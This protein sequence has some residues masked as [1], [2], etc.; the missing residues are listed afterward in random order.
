MS[1][2]SPKKG[3]NSEVALIR[4]ANRAAAI[5]RLMLGEIRNWE[6]FL[7]ADT[8]KL[9]TLP[10]R[11]L[12]HAAG[13]V[14]RSV[15]K[16]V[17]KFCNQ[18]FESMTEAKLES[19]YEE[20]KTFRGLELPLKEFEQRFAKV[21]KKVLKSAP[22]H[23]TV[24]ISLWGLKFKFPEDYLAKDL[25]QALSEAL[26]ANSELD[27]YQNAPHRTALS[28][29]D[30]ITPILRKGDHACR[31]CL[32]IC[33]NLLESYL[34]GIAWDFS[35][36]KSAFQALSKRD[37]SRLKDVGNV[38]VRDKILKY[39]RIITGAHLWDDN[40]EPVK[41]F[42][43]ISK[44]FRDSLVHPSPFSAPEKFGGY[45]KLRKFYRIDI[46]IAMWTVKIT[47]ELIIKVHKHINGEKAKPPEWLSE[48]LT[49]LDKYAFSGEPEAFINSC[50]FS[51]YF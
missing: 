40:D 44:P 38:T 30:E 23:A 1:S 37:Q 20:V 9:D 8:E 2:I 41:N 36:D 27:K 42:L 31:S 21:R 29:L 24:V 16:E 13:D 14:K 4:R 45:D 19:L 50:N 51:I 39:P 25:L 6:E 11:V 34:N 48:I 43:T 28:Q 17:K 22:S 10:R 32:L 35:Q 3:R 18:N 7:K 47:G 33:F 49:E 5:G 12:K 46:G 26:E 15:G